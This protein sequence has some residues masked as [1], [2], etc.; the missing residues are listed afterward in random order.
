M[1]SKKPEVTKESAEIILRPGKGNNVIAWAEQV[2]TVVGAD[3]GLA[4]SFFSTNV[5]Y[6]IPKPIGAYYAP[7]FHPPQEGVAAHPP[8]SATMTATV[9]QAAYDR[10]S[11]RLDYHIIDKKTIY[12]IMSHH[13]VKYWK[14]PSVNSLVFGS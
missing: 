7:V 4:A 14:D 2:K 6:I 8:V 5:R 11:K 12:Y 9:W 3:Y 1:P 10:R 13:K